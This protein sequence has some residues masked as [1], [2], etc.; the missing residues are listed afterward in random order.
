MPASATVK[1]VCWFDDH[2]TPNVADVLAKEADFTVH[3]LAFDGPEDGNWA[4]M[5]TCHAYCI[6]SARDEVPD[7]YKGTRA[8]IERCKELLVLSTSGAGYDPVDVTACT[9]AGI[10]V[11]NQSGANAEAVA[12]HVVAMMLALGKNI[13][14]TDR[15][16]RKERGVDRETF[17]GQNAQGRTVGIIG[18]GEVGRRVARIC[19]KGLEM[20]VLAYDPYLS[21]SDIQE[22]GARPVALDELLAQA[23]YVTI[24]CPFTAETR[25]MIARQELALMRPGAFLIN[26]ARGGIVEEGAL[27]DALAAGQLAGAGI[28]VWTIEPPPLDHRLLTFANV[29][30]TY[31]TAGVTVDSRHAMAAWNA[32]QLVEI[33]RGERPPRLINPEAWPKFSQRFERAFR[34]RPAASGSPPLLASAAQPS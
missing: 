2:K 31:H 20:R 28:D 1:R 5:A 22:R 4:A 26:T 3:R 33:F 34:F 16:L 21:E 11:V 29:I 7:Q 18:L 13:M 9:D 12:E 27:A 32:E 14:Q 25:G 30:G 24:H 8:L 23:D 17:K 6:T 10:L 15:S 19:G